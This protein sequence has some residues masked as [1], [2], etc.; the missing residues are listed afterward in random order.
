MSAAAL[1]AF[2]RTVT[3]D[4]KSATEEQAK[5]HLINTARQGIQSLVNSQTIDVGARPS[6]TVYANT[7]GNTNLE[8]VVLPGPIV[9]LFDHRAAIVKFALSALRAASPVV[10]G[11]YLDNHAIFLNGTKV[12]ALPANL[13]P[14]DEIVITNLVPYSR[15]LEVGKTESGRDFVVQVEPRIYERTLKSKVNR[16]FRNVA[17]LTFG[18]VTLSDA[19]VV[20]GK[21]SPTYRTKNGKLRKRR[22]RAGFGV[23]APAIFIKPLR[24]LVA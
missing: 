18:Y 12:D 19:Y 20:K 13:G 2:R 17:D 11:A 8:S 14:R 9:A 24:A 23:Q 16:R 5:R 22:Q 21:L 7:P 3:V 15:R 4:W 10:S 6:V 1:Q